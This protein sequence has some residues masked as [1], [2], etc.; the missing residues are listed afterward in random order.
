MKKFA[1]MVGAYWGILVPFMGTY[2][3]ILPPLGAKNGQFSF[4][5]TQFLPIMG[6]FYGN[7]APMMG[8]FFAIH[9]R[10]PRG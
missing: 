10:G 8:P 5:M 6:E 2:L 3:E 7:F 9:C 1:P 4:K